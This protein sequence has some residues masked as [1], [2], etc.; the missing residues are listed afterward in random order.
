MKKYDLVIIGSGPAGGKA[1]IHAAY[2]GYKVAV[3]EKSTNLGGAG[4]NTGTLPSKT[5]KE[6]ALY[7]SG[8]LEKGL[9][10]LDHEFTRKPTALDFLFREKFVVKTESEEVRRELLSR[11]VDVYHGVGS[12][13]DAH[14]VAVGEQEI[15]YG[16]YILVAT[17][18]YPAHP[19]RIPF[20][21]RHIHDS[22]TIL[23]IDHI[24][25]SLCIVGAG[26]IG[27]EYATIFAT[28]GTKV[29]L[30]NSHSEILP[31]IDREVSEALV[32]HM[33]KI[34][35]RIEAQAHVNSVTLGPNDQQPIVLTRTGSGIP[36]ETDMFLY[37]AGRNGNTAHLGCENAGLRPTDREALQVDQMYRTPV[38]HIFAVGDVIGFPA[39]GSTSMD[40][41]RVAVTHMF[42]LHGVER[43]AKVFPYGVYTIPEISMVGLTQEEATKQRIDYVIGRALY[44]DVPRGLI[45]GAQEGFLK[46]VLDR[47]TERILGVH[48]FGHQATELIHYGMELVEGEKTLRHI[49]GSVFNFPTLHELY[50]YAAYEV[51]SKQLQMED[52]NERKKENELQIS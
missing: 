30:V 6:T 16:D 1:A 46:L 45:I 3:V 38:P 52:R 13:V 21:G 7:L 43:L 8:A 34:G 31:F 42:G 12:F 35:I 39:L 2:H 11:H 33:R 17:G 14:R 40:Q 19:A 15:L 51:W 41:G 44:R 18:S 32:E 23:Q 26:V 25:S 36:I 20:D 4:V 50:K 10:G 5:L 22:D 37:A 28:L 29:V 9:Y 47:K 24:P 27:C 49:L 48:I